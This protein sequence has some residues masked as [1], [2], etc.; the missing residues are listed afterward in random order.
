MLNRKITSALALTLVVGTL[1]AATAFAAEAKTASFQTAA[2]ASHMILQ[3]GENTTV[4]KDGKFDFTVAV[5][6]SGMFAALPDAG[7]QTFALTGDE[8]VGSTLADFNSTAAFQPAEDAGM[9]VLPL[10]ENTTVSKDGKFDFTVA[11]EDSGMF[12]ALPDAG[13]QTFA[14]TGNEA[15][16]STLADFNSTAAFQPAEDAGMTVLPLGENRSIDNSGFI[17]FS[18]AFNAGCETVN[19]AD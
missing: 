9:T 10:G 6:D 12:A 1:T 14:L 15:V 11:V 7:Y 17:A 16:G 4:S 5:E 8:V 18:K 13:Y 3:L 19:P 2:P